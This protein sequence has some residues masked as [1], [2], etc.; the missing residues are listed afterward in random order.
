MLAYFV[1]NSREER[2]EI[3]KNRSKIPHTFICPNF[4]SR[5]FGAQ[6]DKFVKESFKKHANENES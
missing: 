6:F 2:L 5:L 3:V 1:M 4:K